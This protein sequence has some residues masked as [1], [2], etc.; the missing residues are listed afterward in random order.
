V[1][2]GS[3]QTRYATA[4]QPTTDTTT[5]A[6]AATAGRAVI[7]GA[8][9][10][11]KI[12]PRIATGSGAVAALRV[13]GWSRCMDSNLWIPHLITDVSF[14]TINANSGA[15]IN[16]ASLLSVDTFTKN[17]GEC[18]VFNATSVNSGGFI[19]VDTLGFDLVELA[20]RSTSGVLCNAHIG[21]I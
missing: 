11:M 8:M 3:L 5:T 9:N 21:D 2:S 7:G 12:S 18:V 20:F 13:I 16:G 14:N 1:T 15:T 6:G 10:H 19:L 4:T 17:L